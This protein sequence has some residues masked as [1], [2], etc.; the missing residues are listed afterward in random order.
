MFPDS[1]DRFRNLNSADQ[2]VKACCDV[3]NG[4]DGKR[5]ELR[6]CL[7]LHYDMLW[8]NL[9][10]GRPGAT[11]GE[12]AHIHG[13]DILLCDELAQDNPGGVISFTVDK[14]GLGHTRYV[15]VI[16]HNRAVDV[17]SSLR[18]IGY[19]AKKFPTIRFGSD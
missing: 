12:L 19:F 10:E 13:K 8:K 14:K 1:V 9:K 16:H 7:T 6:K 17:G 5:A 11:F 15:P 3:I 18:T 2:V 4:L